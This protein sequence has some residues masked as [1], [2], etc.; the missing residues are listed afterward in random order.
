[1][2]AAV[3]G[4]A[5]V[6]DLDRY[7]L[8]LA[9]LTVVASVAAAVLPWRITETVAVLTATLTVLLA[10]TLDTSGTRPVQAVADATLL[11]LLVAVVGA[12]EDRSGRSP[13]AASVGLR[14]APARAATP[15]L[16][17]GAGSL[18][19]LTAAQDVVPSVPL[20]LAGLAAAVV[21]FVVAAG[22]HRS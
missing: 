7:V 3:A 2:G 22:A 17:L 14:S 10:G 18:V 20:V 11:V 13:H 8:L 15:A 5:A 1:V 16:A 19:A 6:P 12:R 9:A 4:V 21:A